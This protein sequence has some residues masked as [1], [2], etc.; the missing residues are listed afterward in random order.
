MSATVR[1]GT[2]LA[3]ATTLTIQCP[4]FLTTCRANA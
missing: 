4:S 1:P 2:I 3:K